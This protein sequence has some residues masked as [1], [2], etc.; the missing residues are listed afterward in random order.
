MNYAAIKYCDIANGVGVRTTLFVSGC[1][2]GCPG[3]FN[4]EAW[5]FDAGEPFSAEVQEKILKSLEPY[6]VAG[7]SVLGGEPFEPENQA[8]LRPFLEKVRE[9][10]PQK[11]IWCYSGYVYDRDIA[12]AGG[13]KHTADTNAML[14]CIDVLVDGPY[15]AAEHSVT[16]RFKGSDNQRLIDLAAMKPVRQGLLAASLDPAQAPIILWQDENV[17]AT[18]KFE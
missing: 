16:L 14:D 15:I 1:R 18:H 5:D 17:Y 3:C 2:V 8:A 12:P 9:K 6:W 10:F 7:L 11:T 13:R 4:A